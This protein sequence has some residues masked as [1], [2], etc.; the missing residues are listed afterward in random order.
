MSENE[1]LRCEN[2]HKYFGQ[3]HALE[4]VDFDVGEAEVVGLVGDN[5][6]GK[7]TLIK[8]VCGIYPP[9]KG[10][11]FFKGEERHFSSPQES[12]QA[13]IESIQQDQALVEEMDIKRN[14]FLGREP[15]NNVGLLDVRKMARESLSGLMDMG[16]EIRS[17]DVEVNELSGGQ[18]QGIAIAR[19][20]H[21]NFDL[22]I[23]D[24]PTNNLSIKESK[25]VY[26]YIRK[27][28]RNNLSAILI[29]HA[30]QEVYPVSDR[31][32]VLRNGK[33]IIDKDREEVELDEV[34]TAIIGDIGE[35][36]DLEHIVR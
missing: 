22:I 36:G 25:K 31:I 14:F 35:E 11:L 26:E 1:L 8:V 27:L 33:K 7:S 30:I 24:E 32:V 21:F 17:P 6:A 16:L 15:K 34:E 19:A 18:R 28:K 10:K 4:G 9:T 2:I 12:L 5:G 3:V 20:L 29:S 13:G 23:L